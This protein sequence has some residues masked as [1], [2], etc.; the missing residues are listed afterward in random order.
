MNLRDLFLRIRA[1]AAPRRVEREL[2]EELTFHIE[3]ETQ[4]HIECAPVASIP[5]RRSVGTSHPHM[6]RRHCAT[7]FPLTM[8]R[9]RVRCSRS[10]AVV[11]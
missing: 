8:S 2:Q 5:S 6:R 7:V 4:K 3:R 9:C 1:L 11:A 10:N